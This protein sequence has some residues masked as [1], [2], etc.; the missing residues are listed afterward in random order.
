M[1]HSVL[2]SSTHIHQLGYSRNFSIASDSYQNGLIREILA[3]EGLTDKGFD[4]GRVLHQIS[5][6]KAALKTPEDLADES[7]LPG[8]PQLALLYRKYQL[9]LQL[10][11]ML[12]FDDMLMLTVRLWQQFPEI[13]SQYQG[14][15]SHLMI[16][17]YQDTNAAQLQIML[18]LAGKAGNIA[19]VGDDDQSIY[20]WRGA[21]LGNILQFESYFPNAKII[22]LEQNY[23]ST[24]IILKS[25]NRYCP[26]S[27][28]S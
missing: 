20:G 4:P 2:Q 21:D 9:R 14:K 17:E 6:A 24:N 15:Y 22:R 18:L 7:H 26:Q 16:D 28:P 11:D 23:R 13:L 27:G 1:P 12:D 10:M 5:L 25:A 3:A 19:V 8:A